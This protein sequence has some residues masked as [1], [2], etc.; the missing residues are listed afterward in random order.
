MRH[1]KPYQLREEFLDGPV[2]S[3][4]VDGVQEVVVQAVEILGTPHLHILENDTITA[5]KRAGGQASG[6]VRRLV[7]LRDTWL[8]IGANSSNSRFLHEE[9]DGLEEGIVGVMT[10]RLDGVGRAQAPLQ[11]MKVLGLDLLQEDRFYLDPQ[12]WKLALWVV[13]GNV[14][15]AG[16]RHLK[17]LT[18]SFVDGSYQCVYS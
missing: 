10:P 11:D 1:I 14:Q 2:D 4:V 13:V 3:G 18:R 17:I 7:Q 5:N 15:Y 12:G 6:L 8:A 16:N 9:V